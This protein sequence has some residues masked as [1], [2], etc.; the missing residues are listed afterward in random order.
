MSQPTSQPVQSDGF[1][2]RYQT[3]SAKRNWVEVRAPTGQMSTTLAEIGLSSGLPGKVPISARAPRS[4]KP[5]SPV[6][7]ISSVKRTQRV[8]WMQRFMLSSTCGPSGMRSLPG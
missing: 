1:L 5:S 7:E 8:H 6:F 4:K 3:R 2:S